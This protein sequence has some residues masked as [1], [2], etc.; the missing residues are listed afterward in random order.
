MRPFT[1]TR[2]NKT[3]ALQFYEVP[4]D[5]LEDDDQLVEWVNKSLM[6][7]RRKKKDK[8]AVE[9]EREPL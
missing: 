5:V 8:G 6:V 2:G 7:A 4:V 3:H 1:Y 9:I